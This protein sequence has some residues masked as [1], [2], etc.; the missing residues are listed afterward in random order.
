MIYRVQTGSCY[1]PVIE[2]NLNTGLPKKISCINDRHL[3]GKKPRQKVD[4]SH[5]TYEEQE[6]NR[7]F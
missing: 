2:A 6:L 5:V 1:D 4:D 7:R 3:R